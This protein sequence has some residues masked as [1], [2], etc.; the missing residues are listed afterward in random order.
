[1]SIQLQITLALV[2]IA[3]P[4]GCLLLWASIVYKVDHLPAKNTPAANGFIP[5]RPSFGSL[6]GDFME[7]LALVF[8]TIAIMIVVGIICLFTRENPSDY[9]RDFMEG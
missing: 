1:M 3:V 7:F 2:L 4:I 8:F 5:A 9:F 6:V